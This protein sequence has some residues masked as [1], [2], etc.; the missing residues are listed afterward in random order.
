MRERL[1][2]L[3]ALLATELEQTDALIKTHIHEDDS[4]RTKATRLRELQG[5]G[6]VLAATLLAYVPELGKIESGQ[7]A[8]LIG[9]APF[10]HDSGRRHR[11][12]HMRGGRHSVRQV[13]YMAAVSAIRCNPVM[14]AFYRRLVEAGQLKKIALIAVMRQMLMPSIYWP[15]ILTL[16]LFANTAASVTSHFGIQDD[17][18]L[19]LLTSQ[20]GH[21]E[22][23][24]PR[25]N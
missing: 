1:E 14:R 4:L 21:S 13:L 5:A 11:C 24:I 25:A 8:A 3:R 20:R 6:P 17:S 22:P 7:L 19:T 16:S 23:G 10:A 18:K 15:L 2:I 9:V 12:R